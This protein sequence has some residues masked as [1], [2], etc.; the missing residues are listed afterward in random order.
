MPSPSPWAVCTALARADVFVE[1]SEVR[2]EARDERWLVRLPGQRLAWLAA[3]ASGAERMRTERRVLRILAARCSFAVPRILF[4]DPTGEFDVRTRVPGDADPVQLYAEIRAD[5]GL[6]ARVGAAVGAMLAEQHSRVDADDVVGWLPDRV[7]WPRA[8]AW[9]HQQLPRVVNDAPLIS[10]A[11]G[12]MEAYENVPVLDPDRALVHGDVALHNLAVD[13]ETHRLH[14]LF[15]YADAA[16]ADRH[17]DFQYLVLDVDRWDLLDAAVSAYER[18]ARKRILRDR[19]L[20][21]HAA[22]AITFL[23]SRAGRNPDERWCGRTLRED[24]QWS[25]LAIDRVRGAA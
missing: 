5:G 25:R 24:L 19:V 22:C 10:S 9:V 20:L 16:W 12:V 7:T 17:H 3:S 6:A 14:G 23:A 1:P 4:E 13:P 15:D 18:V 21:Y 8:A 11:I 2:I